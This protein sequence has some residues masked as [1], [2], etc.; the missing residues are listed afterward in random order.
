MLP[1][2]ASS[3]SSTMACTATPGSRS[4]PG[5]WPTPA[6]RSS[7][8][9]RPPASPPRSVADR[10]RRGAPRADAAAAAPASRRPA[11]VPDARPAGVLVR[12]ARRHR[13]AGDQG[14]SGRP[15]GPTHQASAGDAGR[16]PAG[17]GGRPRR[18]H[19]AGP[20]G[21]APLR[22]HAP[23][24][25]GPGHPGRPVQPAVRRAWQRRWATRCGAGSTRACGTTSWPTAP[26][27][28]GCSPT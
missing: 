2:A 11:P 23:A 18:G 8:S 24:A 16:R 21:A 5:R 10:R 6:G 17:S 4:P 26:R 22:S 9:A 28:T 13:C 3:S 14:A 19:G 12:L 25:Q 1:R 20:L 27:S 7:S 15:A